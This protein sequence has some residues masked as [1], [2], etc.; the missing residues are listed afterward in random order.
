MSLSD[1]ASLGSF[2][3]GFGVLVSLVFLYFQLNQVNA[4]VKQSERNQQAS[5]RQARVTRGVEWQMGMKDGPS[6]DV[7]RRALRGDDDLSE[8]EVS[9]F[10]AI[11]RALFLH[12]EDSFYQHSEGLLNETAFVTFSRSFDGTMRFPGIRVA[13]TA[14]SGGFGPEF[15]KFMNQKLTLTP[16]STAGLLTLERWKSDAARERALATASAGVQS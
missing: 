8:T 9:Q 7:W 6:E 5:I 4:Q 10:V 15:E 12:A 14:L 2:I 3:S 13:W 16:V 1:L 11:T